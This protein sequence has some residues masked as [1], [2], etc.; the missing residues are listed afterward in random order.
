VTRA[1]FIDRD[2]TINIDKDY[3]SDPDSLEFIEG[4][5]EAIALANRL[6]LKVII[7]S[8]QAGVA[9]GILSLEQVKAVNDRL[10][11][12]LFSRGARVDDIYFC[13][14]HPQFG[15]M[16]VCECRKPSTGM[17]VM[18]K[19]KYDI[20][21]SSSFVIGDKWSDVKCG[22]N[23]GAQTSLVLTGYG[24]ED[25]QRCIADGI[26]IDYLAK[27]LHDSVTNF[28]RVKLEANN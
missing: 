8:N 4:S 26:R 6:G 15:D 24:Q 17:L 14:H 16:I 12:M 2:G 18:A 1:V 5:P 3:I 28:V 19:A 7:I 21:L 13:P 9:R 10:I 11:E 22:V 25:R 23:A 27:N 20:D